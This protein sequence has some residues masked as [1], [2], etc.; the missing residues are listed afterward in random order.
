MQCS[1]TTTLSTS[2]PLL[3]LGSVG[4]VEVHWALLKFHKEK[5]CSSSPLVL[6]ESYSRLFAQFF[7]TK[8]VGKMI[9]AV[10]VIKIS[11][12]DAGQA[13]DGEEVST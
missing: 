11:H 5:T 8:N 3:L 12:D 10:S 13:P 7:E 1:R 9:A 4:L 6:S 2:R